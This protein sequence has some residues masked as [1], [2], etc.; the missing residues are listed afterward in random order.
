MRSVIRRRE[1]CLL[2]PIQEPVP[3]WHVRPGTVRVAQ[4]YDSN[5]SSTST[6][7]CQPGTATVIDVQHS[8]QLTDPRQN[9]RQK[10]SKTDTFNTHDHV[11]EDLVQ[12]IKIEFRSLIEQDVSQAWIQAMQNDYFYGTLVDAP[13]SNTFAL[14]LVKLQPTLEMLRSG[15]TS[16]SGGDSRTDEEDPTFD[17]LE[18]EKGSQ[19]LDLGDI[20]KVLVMNNHSEPAL[21][22]FLTEDRPQYLIPPHSG[23]VVSDLDRIHGLKGVGLVSASQRGGFDIVVMDP[24]WHNASV[25]RMS[26]YGTMDIY[27]LFKIPI[28]DLV[29]AK[30]E[31]GKGGIVAVWITNRAKVK[32]VVVDKLFPS[33]GLELVAHWFWLKV[34]THGE[35]VLSLDNKHRRPYES[36]LIG[37]QTKSTALPSATLEINR[38]LLVSVPAQHSRKPSINVLL[39]EE[40]FSQNPFPETEHSTN[41]PDTACLDSRKKL[42]LNKLEL[43]AR[44]L[45]EGVLSWGNEPIRHQYCGRGFNGDKMIQDG[46]LIPSVPSSIRSFDAD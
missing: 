26:H 40:F 27:D 46:Y 10:R 39:E 43:F 17:K 3:G 22:A 21:I 36:I 9:K 7:D 44:N 13:A 8:L 5:T 4:P 6:Q 16:T 20:Y 28:P 23:F 45:E 32:K 38:K 15:F 33:W 34:T 41:P 11:Q 29:R 31:H 37:R 1:S 30:D 18:L 19:Q 12:W 35:P 24:P 25:D 2:E 14:D 42:P